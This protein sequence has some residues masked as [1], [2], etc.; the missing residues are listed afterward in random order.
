M[1]RKKDLEEL[2]ETILLLENGMEKMT[3]HMS[4]I[5]NIIKN[6]V[7]KKNFSQSNSDTKCCII[8]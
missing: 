6:I 2:E 7:N 4:C 1:D 3:E 5:D 8:S